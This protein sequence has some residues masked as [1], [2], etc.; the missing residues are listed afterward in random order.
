MS[1]VFRQQY[2]RSIPPN[3]ER[4]T[5]KGKS[6]R[7]VEAVRFKGDDG[8]VVVAPLTR[9]GDRC[10]V[11]SP[12]WYGQFIDTD[13]IWQRVPLCENK[14]A[15]E[16]MLA[17]MIRKAGMGRAGFRDP[18]EGHRKRPLAEHLA[19]WE[20]SLRANG[21][22]D[23]YVQLK[24][25]RVRAMLD[26]CKFTFTADLSADRLEL[27]LDRFRRED[28]R[29]IQTSNDWLQAAKQFTRW[30]VENDRLERSPFARVKGGNV[31]LDRRHGRRDLP[32][33]E[34]SRLLD[35]TRA[36]PAR[37]VACRERTASTCT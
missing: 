22:S 13:G 35:A 1:R 14:A 3:A 20:A 18:F 34:L 8:K 10:R 31:Q 32:P 29:S 4:V 33:A 17:E 6:G 2:T 37:S 27:F 36:M 25:A 24:L 9:T 26:G 23:E 15:S 16:A 28:G 21:R 5:L 11:P 30:L 12:V 19:E 7:T